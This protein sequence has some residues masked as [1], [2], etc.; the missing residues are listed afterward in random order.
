MQRCNKPVLD[1]SSRAARFARLLNIVSQVYF[2]SL[3]PGGSGFLLRNPT[4]EEANLLSSLTL[5]HV[6]CPCPWKTQ[7]SSRSRPLPAPPVWRQHQPSLA[8]TLGDCPARASGPPRGWRGQSACLSCWARGVL[9]SRH[10]P[11]PASSSTF[12]RD[13]D[14]KMLRPNGSESLEVGPRNV[15]INK[16]LRQDPLF[17]LTF[18]SPVPSVPFSQ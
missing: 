14:E 12:V 11:Y 4:W 16:P 5:L 8:P 17:S 9:A 6:S 2:P 18:E 13:A 10:T 7:S 15:G 3:R 1:F